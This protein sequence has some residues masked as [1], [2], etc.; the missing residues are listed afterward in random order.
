MKCCDKLRPSAGGKRQEGEHWDC[1]ECGS[2]WIHLTG[3]ASDPGWDLVRYGMIFDPTSLLKAGDEI[4]RAPEKLVMAAVHVDEQKDETLASTTD[5]EADCKVQE[6]KD[7]FGDICRSYRPECA[8]AHCI[9]G[10]QLVLAGYPEELELYEANAL[11]WKSAGNGEIDNGELFSSPIAPL[12]YLDDWPAPLHEAY[13]YAKDHA[14]AAKVAALAILSYV[15]FMQSFKPADRP[16]K[17]QRDWRSVGMEHVTREE[18]KA[19]G[20]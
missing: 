5:T 11:N 9:G 12:Y 13:R 10:W 8:S 14:A 19:A 7:S 2:E 15:R 4:R 3:E 6:R 17:K 16:W 18:K 20:L 1:P